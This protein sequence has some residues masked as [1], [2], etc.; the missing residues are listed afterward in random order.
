[1]QERIPIFQLPLV[2]LPEETTALH[3]FEPRYQ[4]MTEHCLER[5]LP[6]GIVHEDS[7][8]PQGLGCTARIAEVLERFEDGRSNIA[9]MG[10]RPFRLLE[11]P[12]EEVFPEADVELLDDELEA[13]EPDAE[14]AREAFADLAEQATGN[15]PDEAAISETGSY[16]LAAQVELP[17]ETKHR[18]LELRSEGERLELLERAFRTLIS[19]VRAAEHIQERARTNGKV[20]FGS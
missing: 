12:V 19:T 16:G 5:D 2:L 15:R 9:V 1:M 7:A 6:F 10:E 18:L 4:A 13:V 8:N 17:D 11:S 14:P 3:V 20:R